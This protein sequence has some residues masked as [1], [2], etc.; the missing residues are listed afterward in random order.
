MNIM[1]WLQFTST[2]EVWCR[3]KIFHYIQLVSGFISFSLP[4]SLATINQQFIVWCSWFSFLFFPCHPACFVI[5]VCVFSMCDLPLCVTCHCAWLACVRAL[6]VCSACTAA[7]GGRWPPHDAA[8]VSSPSHLPTPAPTTL[9]N[10]NAPAVP[11]LSPG[12]R[13][14]AVLSSLPTPVPPLVPT[15]PTTAPQEAPP[16]TGEPCPQLLINTTN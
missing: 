5:C 6:H 9:P 10:C 16:A 1:I 2:K 11:P 4:I 8:N 7:D 12:G 3:F 14:H 13:G 15:P